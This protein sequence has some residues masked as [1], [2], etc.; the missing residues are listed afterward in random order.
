MYFFFVNFFSSIR[1][2]Q[3]KKEIKEC[4]HKLIVFAEWNRMEQLAVAM[5]KKFKFFLSTGFFSPIP[6]LSLSFRITFA[7]LASGVI[8]EIDFSFYMNFRA[9]LGYFSQ[10]LRQIATFS[11][12]EILFPIHFRFL[13]ILSISAYLIAVHFFISPVGNIR[14]ESISSGLLVWSTFYLHSKWVV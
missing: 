4:G 9:V 14:L 11:C 10:F 12:H 7:K 5:V 2:V 8:G 3:L 1:R 6:I 13:I